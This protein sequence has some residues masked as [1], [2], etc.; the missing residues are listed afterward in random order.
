M[1]LF[2]QLLL[3]GLA[4]EVTIASN[5]FNKA[6]MFT[7]LLISYPT[8]HSDMKPPYHF[9]RPALVVA[10]NDIGASGIQVEI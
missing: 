9:V 7:L 5:W 4:T 6:G 2:S 3:L 10:A 8:L 1:K